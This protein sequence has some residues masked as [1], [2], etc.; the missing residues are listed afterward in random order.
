[1]KV[2]EYKTHSS[3]YW[4]IIH[5][6]LAGVVSYVP[7]FAKLWGI[8][9]FL[10]GVYDIVKH[11]NRNNQ[12]AYWSAYYVGLEVLLRILK[13]VISYEFA[14]YSIVIFLLLGIIV[15]INKHSS[16]N[17]VLYIY[18]L[19][20]IPGL[21]IVE[22]PEGING[23]KQIL[24]NVSGPIALF[25]AG[26]YFS[27]RSFSKEEL[28]KLLWWL[29]LPIIATSFVLF[30]ITPNFSD[31]HFNTVSNFETSGGFGPNQVSSILG[32]GLFLFLFLF[33]FKKTFSGSF[34]IDLLLAGHLLFRALLTFSRGGIMTCLIAFF[35]CFILLVFYQKIKISRNMVIAICVLP[36]VFYQTWVISNDITGGLLQNRYENKNV[37]GKEKKDITANRLDIFFHEIEA[38]TKYPFLG[39]GP[40]G[41][42]YYR[43][44][45]GGI[46]SST[47]NEIGRM[48]SEHGVFGIIGLLCLVLYSCFCFIHGNVYSKVLLIGFITITFLTFN[49]SAMRIAM[50]SFT[51]G[52]GLLTINWKE[53]EE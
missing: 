23:R 38:F 52:L 44:A 13:G 48:L 1:M 12:A 4:I 43:R 34:I 39:L 7:V 5:F 6:F 53:D 51:Y 49:H 47:H 25:V 16:K 8:S 9:V 20:L 19:C 42:R 2:L 46:A 37:A 36:F 18:L 21:F 29:L 17:L 22:F 24:F 3:I 28:I 50:T 31:I 40:G 27:V 32:L 41:A 30:F 11:R 14:K 26:Y 33:L 35:L 10:Y 15:E 45:H